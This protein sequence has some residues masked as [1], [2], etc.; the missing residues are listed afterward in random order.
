MSQAALTPEKKFLVLLWMNVLA[1]VAHYADNIVRFIHYPEPTWINPTK[2]DVF[3]FVMTPVGIAAYG[4][5]KQGRRRLAFALN[6]A[7]GAMNLFVL[8]HYA[9]QPPWH[10]TLW[11]N[12]LIALETVTAIMLIAWTTAALVDDRKIELPS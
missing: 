4:F 12:V 8:G 1:S 6:F 10:L 7:Y 9:I 3:W 11:I 5:F 2:I